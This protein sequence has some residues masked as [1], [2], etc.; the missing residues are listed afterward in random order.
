MRGPGA[1][2]IPPGRFAGKIVAQMKG[3]AGGTEKMAG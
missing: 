1:L 3:C 2:A